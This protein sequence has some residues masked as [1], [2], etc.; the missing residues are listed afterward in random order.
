MSLSRGGKEEATTVSFNGDSNTVTITPDQPMALRREY[1]ITLDSSIADLAGNAMDSDYSWG[2]RIRDGAWRT[3]ETIESDN[4]GDARTPQVAFDTAGNAI[5]VWKQDSGTSTNARANR[6]TAG[7]G[8]GEAET[9][10]LNDNGDVKAPQI[11]V[12]NAGNGLAVWAQSDGTLDNIRANRYTPD[13]GWGTAQTIGDGNAFTPQIAFDSSGNAI[14]VWIQYDD[15]SQSN[16]VRAN[17]FTPATGWGTTDTIEGDS[18]DGRAPQIGFDGS[19]NALAVWE[20]SSGAEVNIRAN[21]FTPDNGWGSA[22]TID[23]ETEDARRPQIAVDDAGNALAVWRQND[24]TRDNIWANRFSTDNGWGS[25]EKIET[26]DS[27]GAL[28]PQIALDASGNALAVWE[29][30]D[31][32]RYNIRANRY[33]AENGWGGAEIIETDNDGGAFNP[34]IAID[35][36]GNALAV[37]EQ[38]DGTRDNIRANRYTPENGW[39]TD[40]T[41]E[42]DDAGGAQ[43]A[44]IAVNGSGMGIAVWQ[45]SDGAQQNIRANRFD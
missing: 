20:L 7:S 8:W 27:G 41:I 21:R 36:A 32:S 22:E 37:W 2:F 6:Y 26:D 23:T 38:S 40:E 10:E 43:Q 25:A 14:A 19:G 44:Q 9:I 18:G 34:Q 16:I 15:T 31:G 35:D 28:D 3:A 13:N 30:N 4:G 29:Q 11:A 5:A 17:R 1:R 42:T 33:T 39:G 45:Q 12:D 24:G